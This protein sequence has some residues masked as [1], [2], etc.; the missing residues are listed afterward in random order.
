MSLDPW[1]VPGIASTDLDE[2]RRSLPLLVEEGSVVEL[3]VMNAHGDV[4]SGYFDDLEALAQEAASLSDEGLAGVY[5]TLNPVDPALLARAANRVRRRLGKKETA[6]VDANIVGRTRLLIDLDALRPTGISATEAE[7]EAALALARKI[8]DELKAEGWPDPALGSSGNGAH[9]LYRIDVPTVDAGLIERVLDALG[10][11]FDTTVVEVDRTVHNPARITKVFGTVV[12]KGDST[13]DRPHR[14]ARILDAPAKLM[15]V[16]RALLDA[17]AESQPKAPTTVTTSTA[18]PLAA[19]PSKWTSAA[20]TIEDQK[21]RRILADY[22]LEAHEPK[23]TRQ[24]TVY[25][26]V[27][28]P[29]NPEHTGGSAAIGFMPSGAKWFKCQHASCSDKKWREFR[30]LK[31]KQPLER[32]QQR[33]RPDE[34]GEDA[35]PTITIGTKIGDMVE[36]AQTALIA[37]GIPI[38]VNAGRLV[39]VVRD[40][41]GARMQPLPL[42]SLRALLSQEIRWERITADGVRSSLP[43]RE[44]VEALSVAGQWELPELLEVRSEPTILES[45]RVVSTPGYHPD[46]MLF[47]APSGKF[48]EVPES[49]TREDAVKA[50]EQLLE[51]VVDF[52][53]TSPASRSAMISLVLTI[54]ARSAIDGNTPLF[55]IYARQASAGKGLLANVAALIGLGQQVQ[56]MQAPKEDDEWRKQITTQVKLNTGYCTIDEAK[57]L[58]SAVLASAITCGGWWTDRELRSNDTLRGR[59]PV[60][61]SCGNNTSVHGDMARR[62]V[63]IEID[64]KCERPEERKGFRHPRLIRWTLANRPRLLVAA[65]TVLR[66]FAVAGKP[67]QSLSEFGSFESWSEFVR[68][69]LVWLGQADPCADRAKVAVEADE[70]RAEKLRLFTAWYDAVGSEPHSVAQIVSAADRV[71]ELKAACLALD[72]KNRT[73]KVDQRKLG[74]ALRRLRGNVVEGLT[75]VTTGVDRKRNVMWA[76]CPTGPDAGDPLG[77]SPAASPAGQVL[78]TQGVGDAGD[79]KGVETSQDSL[80]SLSEIDHSN[81]SGPAVEPEIITGIT[82]SSSDKDLTRR[83][84]LA[85]DSNWTGW[86]EDPDSDA[87]GH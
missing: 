70:G 67:D 1:H 76:I 37:A 4:S 3:R 32:D 78:G 49:P 9:L 52:P 13:K 36:A 83:Q 63:P 53:F 26:L 42:P 7:H 34:D 33:Q 27:A 28:C 47:Y 35:R 10:A 73:D 38:Y 65:L 40:S 85:G 59:R 81:P 61:S 80:S 5:V 25:P 87:E 2:I 23:E 12:R 48:P 46:A 45:G 77:G 43:P 44:V 6:T 19:A 62:I 29:F 51:V 72:P 58:S 84:S 69:A 60:L 79:Q 82:D 41:S 24:G 39:R 66:A 86:V 50:L 16:P 31:N 71:P 18:A 20:R 22:G 11:R 74:Y 55:M 30:A 57:A 75:L 21:V 68:S 64:P 14:T 54:V 17:L 8:R 15:T 56:I